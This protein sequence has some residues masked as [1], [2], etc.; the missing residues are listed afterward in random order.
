MNHLIQFKKFSI[1]ES[2]TP[3]LKEYSKYK[4]LFEDEKGTHETFCQLLEFGWGLDRSKVFHR[5]RILKSD[6][7][8]YPVGAEFILGMDFNN[9]ENEFLF[10]PYCNEKPGL[11][12]STELHYT[13]HITLI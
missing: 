3:N 1:L 6:S 5:F 10:Y 13:A 2:I 11:R 8:K 12:S 4:L 9:K 7:N